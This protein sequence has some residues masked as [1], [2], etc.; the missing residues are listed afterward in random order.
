MGW[1]NVVDMLLQH[2]IDIDSRD[3]DE[4]TS[5]MGSLSRS[6]GSRPV[7]PGQRR[8]S[9][10]QRQGWYDSAFMGA[11]NGWMGIVQLLLERHVDPN[12]TDRH[13]RAPLSWAAENG[14]D[15]F[16]GLLINKGA[17]LHLRL[18]EAMLNNA[19]MLS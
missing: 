15:A 17:Q 1:T 8:Q 16:M 12:S 19:R 5:L 4:Q 13:D 11:S 2:N 6:R 10:H 9:G 14:H 3:V 7:S 18:M